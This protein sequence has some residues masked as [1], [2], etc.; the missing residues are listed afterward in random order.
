MFRKR[1][2]LLHVHNKQKISSKYHLYY[3]VK[4]VI[5]CHHTNKLHNSTVFVW[6]ELKSQFECKTYQKRTSQTPITNFVTITLY[7][8][9]E[10]VTITFSSHLNHPHFSLAWT[11]NQATHHHFR[12]GCR[13][14]KR[15]VPA[16]EG[17]CWIEEQ[18]WQQSFLCYGSQTI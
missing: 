18:E 6:V 12:D 5:P 2:S 16:T 10:N 7:C 4:N 13:N 9:Q 14:N 15:L 11:S 8:I 17:G 1:L 3:H